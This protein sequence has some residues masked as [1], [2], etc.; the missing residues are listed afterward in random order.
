MVYDSR[1]QRIVLLGTPY[2][3]SY[4]GSTLASTPL[5]AALVGRTFEDWFS[6]PRPT[7]PPTVEIGVIAGTRPLGIGRLFPGLPRPNDGIVAVDETR[8]AAAG[9]SIALDVSHSGMLLS[10]TCAGQVADFLRTGRFVHA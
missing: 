7:L 1:R 9:D 10:S 8:I 2:A 3:G 6:L 5:L 4:C